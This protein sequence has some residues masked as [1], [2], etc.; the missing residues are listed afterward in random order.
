MTNNYYKY[1]E[2][3]QGGLVLCPYPEP[4]NAIK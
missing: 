3:T 4:L 1:Q 2:P